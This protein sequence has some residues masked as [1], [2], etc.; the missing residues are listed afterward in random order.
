MEQSVES[1]FFKKFKAIGSLPILCPYFRFFFKKGFLRKSG[2]PGHGNQVLI[3]SIVQVELSK[4][5][6]NFDDIRT[7][8]LQVLRHCRQI[9]FVTL[10]GFCL[11][12]KKNHPLFLTDNIK[13]NRTGFQNFIQHFPK[14]RFMSKIFLSKQTHSTT[15]SHHHHH[16]HRHPLNNQNPLSLTKAFCQYSL[17][18]HG[19]SRL[20]CYDDA[21]K[22]QNSRAELTIQP[23]FS[24]RISLSSYKPLD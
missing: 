9:T 4:L 10:N 21:R 6:F 16:H 8:F 5:S 19:F 23:N 2:K 13:M 14:K 22:N 15:P 1:N 20:L 7:Y 3:T 17:T 24:S 18:Y 11:L 12:S